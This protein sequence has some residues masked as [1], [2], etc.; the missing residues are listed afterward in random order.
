MPL[1]S[2]IAKT[3]VC[4]SV[5]AGLAVLAL[6]T[7]SPAAAAAASGTGTVSGT[8]TAQGLRDSGDI[9][10][11]LEAPGLVVTPPAAPAKMDQKNILFV[12]HVLPVVRGT[13]V[14]FY[15]SDHE[16]HNVYSPEGRYNL[17]TWPFGESRD[18]TFEQPGIFTQL[19]RIH[20]DMLAFIVVLETP[21]FVVTDEQGRFRIEGVPAGEYRLVAWSEEYDYVEQ[22]VTVSMGQEL[23]VD[24]M[25]EP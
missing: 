25:M 2:A 17:G 9:V 12:P 1:T 22:A 20:P 11:S 8:V 7:L 23:T 24:V 13:T 16:P 19:C 21:Y 3:S 18:Y 14:R 6:A 5:V 10:V 15:N 4:C